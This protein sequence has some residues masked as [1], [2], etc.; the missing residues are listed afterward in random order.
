[1]KVVIL[2]TFDKYGGAA[3]AAQRLATAIAKQAV[4]ICMIVGLKETDQKFIFQVANKSIHWIKLSLEKLHFRL[5]EKGKEQ[6]FGFSQNSF[7]SQ[8]ANLDEVKNADIIH[9]HWVN[10]GFLSLNNIAQ[11]VQMG[12]PIIVTMHDMW[13]FTGGCHYAGNCHHFESNCGNCT[14]FLKNPGPHDFSYSNWKKKKTLF[15]AKN[16]YFVGCSFWMAQTAQRSSILKTASICNIPNPI[17]TQQFTIV[18]KVTVFES[19]GLSAEKSYLLF[20][21]AKVN[22]KRKGL[23]YLI[24]ALKIFKNEHSENIKNLEV[25]VFGNAETNFEEQ[26]PFKVHSLGNI[27][28]TDTLV[29]LYNAAI[30]YV[31]PSLE[32]NLPNTIM[33]AMAC[34]CPVVAFGTGG[35]PEMIEH[36][37]NGYLAKASNSQDLAKGIS[38]VMQNSKELGQAARQKV[39]LQYSEEVVAKQYIKLY[40]TAQTAC[41]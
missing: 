15:S 24:E 9:L 5:Y 38:F 32:D 37:K 14:T 7:G 1:M 11:L 13:Y 26:I 25:V 30:L 17:D 40:Q 16:L 23:N 3:I 10:F 36:K 8:L 33:E 35:I 34:A 6:R 18:P 41:S 19:L 22:D 29:Q 28:N 21:A 39:L 27:T 2:N 12:K 31:S 20:G 4:D